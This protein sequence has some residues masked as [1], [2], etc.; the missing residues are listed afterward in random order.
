MHFEM[1]ELVEFFKQLCEYSLC[2]FP[3]TFITN[4]FWYYHLRSFEHSLLWHSVW[5][6]LIFYQ[7]KTSRLF[8]HVNFIFPFFFQTKLH[9]FRHS[10]WIIHRRIHNANTKHFEYHWKRLCIWQKMSQLNEWCRKYCSCP[11][12]LKHCKEKVHYN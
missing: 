5:V 7:K 4:Y 10:Y 8:Y 12:G 6:L 11:L 2:L 1:Q 9:T 3:D